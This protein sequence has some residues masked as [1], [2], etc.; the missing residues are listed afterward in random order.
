MTKIRKLIP[1]LLIFVGAVVGIIS[2]N[3]H[4]REVKRVILLQQL[5]SVVTSGCQNQGFT[6]DGEKFF[7]A[8]RGIG[9]LPD[10]YAR[11]NIEIRWDKVGRKVKFW[12][13]GKNYNNSEYILVDSNCHSYFIKNRNSYF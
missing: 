5:M 1:M 7:E 3:L 11:K 12:L 10:I 13:I 2:Y 6:Y 4:L 9:S 8:P